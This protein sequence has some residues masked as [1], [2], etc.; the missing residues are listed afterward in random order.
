MGLQATQHTR[1]AA[2]TAAS[3]ATEKFFARVAWQWLSQ[4]SN[5]CQSEKVTYGLFGFGLM[6]LTGSFQS[7]ILPVKI[8]TKI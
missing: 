7:R 4:P 3:K 1:E 8:E 2:T 6:A 5:I